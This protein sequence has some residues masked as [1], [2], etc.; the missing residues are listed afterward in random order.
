M[1]TIS[2]GVGLV[3]GLLFIELFSLFC[4]GVIVPG[5]IALHLHNPFSVLITLIISI[6]TYMLVKALSI[7]VMLYGRRQYV[8]M[9]LVAFLLGGIFEHV[10]SVNFVGDQLPFVLPGSN[11]DIFGVIGYVIPG[12]VANWYERQGVVTT[13][14]TVITGSI[15][16]RL[17][18]LAIGN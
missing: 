16:V 12:L 8:A 6:F 5:Y 10:A 3:V 17:V 11:N 2:I 14:C 7:F 9:L 4:G 15:L 13:I 18:L 1:L